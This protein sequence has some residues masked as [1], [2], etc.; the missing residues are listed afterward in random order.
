LNIEE[1]NTDIHEPIDA[2]L[3]ST[4]DRKALSRRPKW[5]KRL[6]RRF[7]ANILDTHG[8]SIILPI[9]IS[10]TDTSEVHS[11]KVLLDSRATG[12]FIDRDFVYAKGIST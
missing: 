11:V 5:K 7:S 4:L 2:P 9:K 6:L 8:T 12:N 1:V 3:P 10:T